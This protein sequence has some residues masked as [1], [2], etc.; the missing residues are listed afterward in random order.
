M[1]F[2]KSDLKTIVWLKAVN[3]ALIEQIKNGKA[4]FQKQ[5]Y[6]ERNYNPLSGNVYHGLNQIRLDSAGFNDKRWT[7]IKMAKRNGLSIKKGEY[8]TEIMHDNCDGTVSFHKLF[9]AE[10]FEY[11]PETK[12]KPEINEVDTKIFPINVIVQNV[13]NELFNDGNDLRIAIVVSAICRKLKMKN[14][15]PNDLENEW[16]DYIEKFGIESLIDSANRLYLEIL[17]RFELAA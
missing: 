15:Y 10:Q 8:A 9:N 16:I 13:N 1:T 7:T 11:F 6:E 12:R 5:Y 4:F 3:N 14:D 17:N 2:Y